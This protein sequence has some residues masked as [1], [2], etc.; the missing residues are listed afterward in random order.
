M[1]KLI[2]SIEHNSGLVDTKEKCVDCWRR[3][4]LFSLPFFQLFFAIPPVPC[5]IAP[6]SHNEKALIFMSIVTFSLR[7]SRFIY[8]FSLSLESKSFNYSFEVCE[9][10]KSASFARDVRMSKNCTTILCDFHLHIANCHLSASFDKILFMTF[11]VIR[12]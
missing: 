3:F 6:D 1:N 5:R 7:Q 12:L 2:F 11:C 8:F 10:W 4:S 9:K